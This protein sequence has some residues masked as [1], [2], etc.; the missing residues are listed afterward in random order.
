MTACV[1]VGHL[2]P[3][4]SEAHIVASVAAIVVELYVMGSVLFAAASALWV[5]RR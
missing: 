5:L 3:T 1:L 4:T 2:L